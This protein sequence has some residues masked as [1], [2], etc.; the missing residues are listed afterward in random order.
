MKRLTST[1]AATLIAASALALSGCSSMTLAP[2]G[3]QMGPGGQ[4][5]TEARIE[6]DRYRVTYHGVGAAA[7][8]ADFALFRAAELTREQGYDWFEVTQRWVDGRPDSA[9][10]FRPNISIGYGGGSYRGRYGY[11]Y[12]N[13]GVGV[14]VGF[15]ISPPSA[16]STSLEIV[17]GRGTRPDR[18]DAYGADEVLGA[19]GPRLR[20]P[21]ARPY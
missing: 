21:M 14:G 13:S 19:I 17:M 2:Y 11:R 3:A 9:G 15:N 12:S 10:S 6:S 8:V 1:L 16:T 20:G 18:L 5:F 4:G 7:P